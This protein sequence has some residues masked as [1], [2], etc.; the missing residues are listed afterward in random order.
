MHQRVNVSLLYLRFYLSKNYRATHEIQF[1]FS[2]F[3]VPQATVLLRTAF[4]S[5]QQP[6]SVLIPETCRALS[7]QNLLPYR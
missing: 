3:P 5:K 1:L 7:G 2:A 6:V 4:S